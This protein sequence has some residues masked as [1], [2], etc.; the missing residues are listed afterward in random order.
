M[1]INIEQYDVPVFWA[2]G[3]TVKTIIEESKAEGNIFIECFREISY[4]QLWF[5]RQSTQSFILLPSALILMY[6]S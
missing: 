1:Y 2:C 6:L 3:V 5:C 4:M